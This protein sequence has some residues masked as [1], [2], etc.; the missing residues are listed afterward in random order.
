ALASQADSRAGDSCGPK[1]AIKRLCP[2]TTLNQSQEI[3]HVERLRQEVIEAADVGENTVRACL[4]MTAYRNEE[5]PTITRDPANGASEFLYER[6]Q[7]PRIGRLDKESVEAHREG[8]VSF[9]FLDIF[10]GNGDENRPA[11]GAGDFF[12]K[13]VSITTRHLDVEDAYFRL[14]PLEGLGD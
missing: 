9:A 4:V 13:L 14:V 12:G 2:L 5:R 7:L 6:D 1:P 11:R 10:A 3:L 8:E